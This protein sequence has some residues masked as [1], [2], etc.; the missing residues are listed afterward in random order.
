MERKR[1]EK[2]ASAASERVRPVDG[3]G[4]VAISPVNVRVPVADRAW[5]V[6][7]PV[8]LRLRVPVRELN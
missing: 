6:A 4:D 3:S 8:Q 2:R 5:T 7:L 1:I